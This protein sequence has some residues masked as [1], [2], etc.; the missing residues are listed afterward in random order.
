VSAGAAECPRGT[1]GAPPGLALCPSG[2]AATPP[3]LHFMTSCWD[4]AKL[5]FKGG[6]RLES[7]AYPAEPR[8]QDSNRNVTIPFTR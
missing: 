4:W 2:P 5:V 1:S 8:A 7:K 6:A 3:F